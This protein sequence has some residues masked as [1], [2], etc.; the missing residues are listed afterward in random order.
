MSD[1]CFRCKKTVPGAFETIAFEH[2]RRSF[3]VFKDGLT[4]RECCQKEIVVLYEQ[5]SRPGDDQL[6]QLDGNQLKVN[7][8]VYAKNHRCKETEGYMNQVLLA[9]GVFF[10]PPSPGRSGWIILDGS[11]V[12]SPTPPGGSPLFFGDKTDLWSYAKSA[13]S[14]TLFYWQAVEIVDC[15]SKKE[16]LSI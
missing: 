12:I 9:L 3:S 10:L 8:G 2:D 1:L 6:F 4:C 15:L 7:W 11:M 14:G 16:C 5:F 13:W